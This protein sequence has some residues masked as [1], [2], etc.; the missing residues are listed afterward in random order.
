M[1]CGIGNVG[2]S[3]RSGTEII[4]KQ[5]TDG[6][7]DPRCAWPTAERPGAVRRFRGAGEH[8]SGSLGMWVDVRVAQ[9]QG[10]AM[11]NRY[12]QLVYS[13]YEQA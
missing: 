12:I 9:L 5:W 11:E 8:A 10:K 1:R 4:S 6:D 3:L 7:S 2:R 13:V